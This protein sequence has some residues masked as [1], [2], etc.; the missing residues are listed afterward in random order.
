MC[1]FKKQR[2]KLTVIWSQSPLKSL[3]EVSSTF[4]FFNSLVKFF[5][6]GGMKVHEQGQSLQANMSFQ[7][8]SSVVVSNMSSE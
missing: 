4:F 2:F 8:P 7:L 5:V 3:M 6:Q 1:N